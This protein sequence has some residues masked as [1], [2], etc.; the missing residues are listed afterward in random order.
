MRDVVS[1]FCAA[2]TTIR[3][4]TSNGSLVCLTLPSKH[5]RFREE[6]V[7]A[8]LGICHAEEKSHDGQIPIA[9]VIR[10]SSDGQ[11]RRVGSSE[12]SSLEHQEERVQAFINNRWG[13]KAKVTWYKSIG[14]GMNFE[15]KPFLQ[16]IQHILSGKFNWG[17]IVATDFT[18]VCRFGIKLVKFLA[19]EGGCR[20]IYS[21]DTTSDDLNESLTDEIL[22]IL[23]H[24]TATVRCIGFAGQSLCSF[25]VARVGGKS[26]P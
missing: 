23:T 8:W 12:K 25:L 5:R 15:R 24:Y 19:A 9:A 2:E 16:L 21:M 18:R 14:S 7:L 26:G 1:R 4:A 20:I 11:A 13:E 22:S 6:D 3:R 17:F 10:V